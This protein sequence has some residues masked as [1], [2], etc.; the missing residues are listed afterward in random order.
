MTG[1]RRW[2]TA[3][4]VWWMGLIS[5]SV[6]SQPVLQLGSD[7]LCQPGTVDIPV[8]AQNFNGIA[9]F[10]LLITADPAVVNYDTLVQI[11]P[12]LQSGSAFAMFTYNYSQDTLRV[13]Y[14][15]LLP[16]NLGNDTLFTIRYNLNGGTTALAFAPGSELFDASALLIPGVSWLDGLANL[17]SPPP[18]LSQPPPVLSFCLQDPVELLVDATT[19][20]AFRWQYADTATGSIWQDAIGGGYNGGLGPL[21][22]FTAQNP[23]Q[24]R[25][26]RCIVSHYCAD[27]TTPVMVQVLPLPNA[28]AG[29]D[30]TILKGQSATLYGSGGPPY[31]WSTGASTANTTVNPLITTTYYLTVDNGQCQGVDSVVITVNTKDTIT[32]QIGSFSVCGDTVLVPVI[33]LGFDSVAALGFYLNVLPANAGIASFSFLTQFHPGFPS[34][35]LVFHTNNNGSL[36]IQWTS[37]SVPLPFTGSDTLFKIRLISQGGSF[38]FTWN[39]AFTFVNFDTLVAY[40]LEFINGTVT[41]HP[42]PAAP[43]VMGDTVCAGSAVQLTATGNGQANWYGQSS[44]GTPLFNGPIYDPG[45]NVSGTYT[46]YAATLDSNNCLSPR[47]PVSLLVHPLPLAY[48]GNDSTLN[49]GDTAVLNGQGTAGLPPYQFQWSPPGLVSSPSQAATSTLPLTA[50][51]TFS[52]EVTDAN[53]C[54]DTDDVVFTVTG[55]PLSLDSIGASQSLLCEGDSCLL[56]AFMAGGTGQY[57]YTWSPA[58]LFNNP[59][60]SQPMA[61]PVS[62]GLI[63]LTVTD[64]VT[65]DSV[66]G[67]RLLNVTPAPQAFSLPPDTALCPGLTTP[68]VLSGSEV[69]VQYTLFHNGVPIP[70]SLFGNGSPLS[71]GPQSLPGQYWVEAFDTTHYCFSLTVDTMT[72]SLL[73]A[74]NS[75]IISGGDT[76]ICAGDSIL[77][78]AHHMPG[79]L[80][81]WFLDSTSLNVVGPVLYAVAPGAY[82]VVA[83][84]MDGC[85]D[86]SS[87]LVINLNP[88]PTIT[89]PPAF[90]LC[91]GDSIQLLPQISGGIAPLQYAWSGPGTYTLSSPAVADPWFS[92]GGGFYY[93]NLE[94]TDSL[95]CMTDEEAWIEV[96]SLPQIQAGPDT[97]VLFNTTAQVYG[98]VNPWDIFDYQWTPTA[99]VLN[100][101]QLSSTTTPLQQTTQFQITATDPFSGC[102]AADSMVVHVTGGP[103]AILEI[104]RN[105]DTVCPGDT[106][107]LEVLVSG[108]SGQFVY[109]WWS[110]ALQPIFT[111]PDASHTGAIIPIASLTYISITVTDTITGLADTSY[112]YAPTYPSPEVTAQ[113]ASVCEQDSIHLQ[114]TLTVPTVGP[115]LYA[116]SGPAGYTGTG[117]PAH[118]H[119]AALSHAGQY[120]VTVTDGRGCRNTATSNVIVRRKPIIDFTGDTLI[121]QGEST[122]INLAPTQFANTWWVNGNP[123]SPPQVTLT[124]NQNTSYQF[125]ARGNNCFDT[126]D[127]LITVIPP[128]VVDHYDTLCQGDSIFFAG[129][130]LY[131]SGIYDDSLSGAY[132]CDSINRLHLLVH[133]LPLTP[134]PPGHPEPLHTPACEHDTAYI[135]LINSQS[136]ISYQLFDTLNGLPQGQPLTGN[137]DTLFFGVPPAGHSGHYR[138]LA[139]DTLSGCDIVWDTVLHILHYPLP[140]PVVGPDTT[141]CPGDSVQLQAG[142]GASYTWSTGAT[143]TSIWVAPPLT[144]SYTVTVSSVH[145]CT[146]EEMVHISL[147]PAVQALAGPDL[148]IPF[149]GDTLLYGGAGGSIGPFSY[150]W[151]PAGLLINPAVP[152]PQTQALT[153]TTVFN[154][155][156]SDLVTGCSGRDSMTVWVSGGPLE[157]MMVWTDPPAVC[158]GDSMQLLATINGGAGNVQY[159]WDTLG[160]GT[161]STLPS[162]YLTP[163]S[164]FTMQLIVYDSFNSDTALVPIQVWTP[165]LAQASG[166]AT[167][168]DG[169]EIPLDASGGVMYQWDTLPPQ[170]SGSV[171][172]TVQGSGFITVTVY[173]IHGCSDTD[174]VYIDALPLPQLLIFNTSPVCQGDTF[175]LLADLNL[176]FPQPPLPHTY[177]WSGPQGF[178][179]NLYD[180]MVQANSTAQAGNYAFTFI[181]GLGCTYQQTSQVT[182]Y[183]APVVG[184]SG[185]QADYCL[186][187]PVDTVQGFSIQTGWYTGAGMTDLGNGTG[188]FNPA[189]AGPGT[190]FITYGA[191]GPF[192]CYSDTLVKLT[193]YPVDTARIL[194][195]EQAYCEN[196][197]IDTLFGSP[198]TGT[199][200]GPGITNLGPGLAL[201]NPATAGFGAGISITYSVST[202]HGCQDD[203]MMSTIVHHAPV[204]NAGPD[205]SLSAGNDTTLYGSATGNR[206]HIDWQPSAWLI[207]PNVLMPTTLPLGLTTPFVLTITDTLT[208]C[209]DRDT[210][211]VTVS[212]S[213]LTI[214]Q[215]SAQPALVC[216][217]DTVQLS[218]TAG[219]GSGYYTYSWTPPALLSDSSLRQPL[220]YPVSNTAFTVRVTDQLTGLFRDTLIQIQVYPRPQVALVATTVICDGGNIPLSAMINIPTIPAYS[221]TWSGPAGFTAYI[222]DTVLYNVSYWATGIYN[223]SVTDGRGCTGTD[224]A[225]IT[226]WPRPVSS[227]S[228]DT[229]ETCV[230]GGLIGL[231]PAAGLGWFIGPGLAGNYFDPALAGPGLATVSFIII[232]SVACMD[233]AS[234]QINVHALPMHYGLTGGGAYCSADTG[235]HIGLAGS[236]AHVA[237]TLLH[238]GN[239]VVV[240]LPGSGSALD[241]GLFSTAGTYRVYARDTLTGCD[242]T[243]SGQLS[244]SIITSPVANAGPDTGFCAGGSVQLLGSGGTTYQ[245]APAA[246]LSNVNISNPVASPT[247]TTWYHLTVTQNGCTARDSVLVTVRP[248]P[249]VSCGPDTTLCLGDSVQLQAGGGTAYQWSPVSSLSAGNISN[250]WAKP[251]VTTTYTVTVTENGCTATDN[252]VVQIIT[253]SGVGVSPD[254]SLC[255]G[256]S[257]TLTATGGS[258]YAWSTV[259]PASTASVTVQPAVT[260]TYSV[261][262]SQGNCQATESVQVTIVPLPVIS[263]GQ[264]TAI[265][266]GDTIPLLAGGGTSYLWAPAAG[267]SAVNIPNPL[268]SPQDTTRYYVTVTANGCSATDSLDIFVIPLPVAYAGL[269]TTLCEGDTA[270]LHASGGDSYLWTPATGLSDP[271]IPNPWAV[272]NAS[273]TYVVMVSRGLCHDMDTVQVNVAPLPVITLNPPAPSL[274]EGDTI[275]L[276]AGGAMLYQWS[277][278]ADLSVT[279]GNTVKAFPT[280]TGD[281]RIRA[282]S[283]AGCIDSL[284]FTITV[285]PLP[286]LG[287]QMPDSILCEGD[288]IP[289][290]ASGAS[291]YTWWPA[292]GL[293]TTQGPLVTASPSQT[294]TYTLT[295]VSVAGCQSTRDFQLI[296]LERPMVD[297]GR[298]RYLCLGE[299]ILLKVTVDDPFTALSWQDG[300]EW[301]EYQVTLPGIYWVEANNGRCSASDTVEIFECTLLWVPNAFTPTGDGINDYFEP[302][303]STSLQ[304]YNIVIYNRWGEMVFESDQIDQPWDGTFRGQPCPGGVYHYVIHYTGQADRQ[305]YL[306]NRKTGHVV[307]IR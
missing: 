271:N 1:M 65:G 275:T 142:G 165:P 133:P 181:D 169:E 73:P 2:M 187:D 220:A 36:N 88:L 208:G 284:L 201:F 211:I 231:T 103:L 119:P 7:S 225:S 63:G 134:G 147:H 152:Q 207:N 39:T 4:A 99:L 274:C 188:Y 83:S 53:A 82:S 292:Q 212:S 113:N 205:L 293:S 182:I 263:L 47:S 191:F 15:D 280:A 209:I 106:M 67:F 216:Q 10:T 33:A 24:P 27:T 305:V 261:T 128:L 239:P 161:H 90:A 279:T 236:Q 296:V 117:N 19:A 40:P 227:L 84:T 50:T 34:P 9:A 14:L 155:E 262:I 255:A 94:V 20:T 93:L 192:G 288:A 240:N 138:F 140:I 64:I 87:P 193:V 151:E 176:A 200:S 136:G 251:L 267:L 291:Q 127:L 206:L 300:S 295:G 57:A 78:Q 272:L 5:I 89:F 167:V 153:A 164:S 91:E 131:N 42:K 172:W 77:I 282:T 44:G 144:T 52:L 12:S 124:P 11:H 250:P 290:Q 26:Y 30:Q 185:F 277:P 166:G 6:S 148:L 259:P 97:T 72:I 179:V 178:Q 74:A 54:T 160:G 18:I 13:T 183:P 170:S 114:A 21:L 268:A 70:P 237:Y 203:T 285:H 71:F 168:C 41:V 301:P 3:W 154:L 233:T 184:V 146:A 230:D 264:D 226:V 246:G 28:N 125:I 195:L 189:V 228:A 199:F 32:L 180:V 235:V 92:A 96:F 132:G 156:V 232:D 143:G 145:G 48:A 37:L 159:R 307:L 229:N 95:G 215:I 22:S 266:A 76:L 141:I 245:W 120:H 269:D 273:Q 175:F 247:A 243:L 121:C 218:V 149:G 256:Q 115:Y 157:I 214:L 281:F 101:T 111:H 58:A 60:A 59:F 68:M 249:L 31:Q 265:C 55:G 104:L 126:L 278:A 306:R 210:M 194:G 162:P 289:V 299:V 150:L 248:L 303:A 213:P 46:Y 66:M 197:P 257:V 62:T 107:W 186:N 110:N 122:L 79:Y 287:L 298:D 45:S 173:D 302:K 85:R 25:Q 17:V 158:P 116:W 204:A 202:L 297:L 16:L 171:Q 223:L 224:T 137:G 109:N 238:N 38:Q 222:H 123:L 190:H 56:T 135:L 258:T 174:S 286:I 112:F 139:A 270:W 163:W 98:F 61:G 81:E 51:Q 130:Y 102:S 276:Q 177:F 294:T 105:P 35:S 8:L 253:L 43:V 80:H 100:P 234:V 242:D 244:I 196:S 221:Y 49:Y 129:N 252:A 283:P 219:G 29:P 254:T 217:G 260:T 69:G 198:P 241:F 304:A 118:R 86:T 75:L 108:G 23:A